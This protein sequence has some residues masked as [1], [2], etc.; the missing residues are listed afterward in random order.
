MA[1]ATP[2]QRRYS[3]S[4]TKNYTVTVMKETTEKDIYEKLESVPNVNGYIKG[5]IRADIEAA[6]ITEKD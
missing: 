4:K 5:L 3:V 2:S 6:T 1:K